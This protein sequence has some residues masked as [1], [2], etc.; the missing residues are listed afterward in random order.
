[1]PTFPLIK[2]GTFFPLYCPKNPAL[3]GRILLD[4]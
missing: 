4:E 1:M 2:A 3:E